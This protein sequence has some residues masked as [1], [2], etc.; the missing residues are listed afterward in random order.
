MKKLMLGTAVALLASSAAYAQ[1]YQFE[2]G[3]AYVNGDVAGIDYDGYGLNAEFHLDKV[4]TTK[5]P[6][7]EAT[8]LDKSSSA[9]IT[10][11]TAELDAPGSESVDAITLGGRF[12]TQKNLIIEA[13]YTDIDSVIGETVI[14]LGVGTYINDNTDVVVSYENY[15]EADQSSFAVD[16]HGINKLQGET[17]LAYDLG[18]S[19]LDINSESGYDLRAGADYYLNKAL[20]FGA[21]LSLMSVDNVDVSTIDVRADYFVTPLVALGLN[22]ETLGQ[23][24]DGDTVALVAAVRF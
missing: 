20:S 9:N 24:G 10:W 19:Y 17:S 1:D 21:G 12:V 14:G 8:F 23:D 2:V 11:I 4:D 18:L 22:Y 3:A 16:V 6:L 5:G 13:F 15:D 7:S